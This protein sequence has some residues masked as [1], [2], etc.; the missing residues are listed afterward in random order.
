MLMKWLKKMQAVI[1]RQ[2]QAVFRSDL[3]VE[4]SKGVVHDP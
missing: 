4:A 3:V 1:V 2:H